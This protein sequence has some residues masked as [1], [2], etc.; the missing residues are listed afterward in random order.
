MIFFFVFFSSRRRHTRCALVTGVQTCAL[1]IGHPGATSFFF[2]V[3][4]V[5]LA[6][7]VAPHLLRQAYQYGL[8][9]PDAPLNLP[10]EPDRLFDEVLRY[11]QRVDGPQAYFVSR[12]R[13]QRI[14][15]Q[16]RQRSAERRVG[17]GVV[18]RGR[19]QGS[20]SH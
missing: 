7:T 19:L 2:Y 6:A 18:M 9:I 4:L 17:K 10:H 14:P 20:R 13:K 1:P 8:S 3:T 15:L 5:M 16:R 12:F 11:L